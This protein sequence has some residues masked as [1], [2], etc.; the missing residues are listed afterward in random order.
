MPNISD[1]VP[2]NALSKFLGGSI[3][4]FPA[5]AANPETLMSKRMMILKV[6]M[7]LRALDQDGYQSSNLTMEDP[8][9]D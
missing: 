2:A 7:M 5:R 8:P 4:V 1:L 3:L 9:P 6:P